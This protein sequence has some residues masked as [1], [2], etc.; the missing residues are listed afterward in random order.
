[1]EDTPD[2]PPREE[3]PKCTIENI[4]DEFIQ[5]LITRTCKYRSCPHC[6][7]GQWFYYNSGHNRNVR[8]IECGD[9]IVLIG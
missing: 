3:I 9:E 1:M 2:L 8:C 6:N 5:D 4:P 7:Q